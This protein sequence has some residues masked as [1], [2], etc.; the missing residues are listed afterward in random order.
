MLSR[1]N[2]VN[3]SFT[4]LRAQLLSQPAALTALAR[5]SGKIAI[6]TAHRTLLVSGV[7]AI[8]ALC[9]MFFNP[10]LADRLKALSPFA[11]PAKAQTVAVVAPALSDLLD[12]PGVVKTAMAGIQ[13]P[14][15]SALLSTTT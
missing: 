4:Q 8:T 1:M 2:G 6:A 7:A 13:T 9:M 12:P 15:S 5:K 14:A 10:T 11:E 3:L